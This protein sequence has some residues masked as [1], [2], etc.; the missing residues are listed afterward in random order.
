M[1]QSRIEIFI[2]RLHRFPPLLRKFIGISLV[3][4]GILGFLPVLGFWM[5]PIG[6]IVLSADYRFARYLYVNAK[7][8]KRRYVRR[9][10]AASADS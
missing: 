10:K 2:E 6:L 4:L 7:L 9:K 3:M 5:I 8:M 1:A